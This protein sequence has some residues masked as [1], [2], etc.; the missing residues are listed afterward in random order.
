MSFLKRIAE[1]IVQ[2]AG[3]PLP[4]DG[5][6]K[7]VGLLGSGFN[8][9]LTA[10]QKGV[11]ANPLAMPLPPTPPDSPNDA[12]AQRK[13]NQALLTY[14]QRFQT[15]HTQMLRLFLQRFQLMQQSVL[16]MQ[17]TQGKTTESSLSL[18]RELGVGGI[19][20]SETNI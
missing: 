12:E 7:R 11:Q 17:R 18:Q 14:N 1:V 9:F 4:P 8:Q 2:S 15:Y 19:L 20:D 3:H 16:Q 5:D 13:Y 6:S 10:Q